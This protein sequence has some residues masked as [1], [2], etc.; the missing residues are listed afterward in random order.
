M[1]KL[2][3]MKGIVF[4]EFLEMVEKEFGYD[5]VDHIIEASKL[6]SDGI[7]TAVGTYPFS[8]ML[9]L[10]SNLSEKIN[11]EIPS[12]LHAFGKYLFDTFLKSYPAFFD[13]CK[14][15]F[16]FLD[17]IDSYIHIEVKKLYHDAELP[18]FQSTRINESE[19]E[20]VYRSSRK[21]SD[22]AEG[23][24]DKSMSYYKHEYTLKKE[25]LNPDGSEVK[26]LI[27]LT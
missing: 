25:L 11:V 8:E 26:F 19:M 1:Y 2:L 7:Y 22:F 12:L 21:M 27:K 5:T 23:L 18:A 6:E 13:R 20:L 14:D 17:S 16:S 9:Q 24:I 10:V 3:I 4:T 15:G